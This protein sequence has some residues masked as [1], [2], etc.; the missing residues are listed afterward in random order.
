MGW[1]YRISKEIQT[2]KHLRYDP[3]I[4]F[5]IK[6]VFV[7]ENGDITY[8]RSMPVFMCETVDE[9]KTEIQNML[10]GCNKPMIDYNTGEE[11]K[12]HSPPT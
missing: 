7:G 4:V 9:L 10:E 8:I 1:Q 2:H 5:G 3:K 6:K 12:Q 11:V